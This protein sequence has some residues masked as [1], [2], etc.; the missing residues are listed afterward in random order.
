MSAF[1]SGKFWVFAAGVTLLVLSGAALPAWAEDQQQPQQQ[2]QRLSDQ[3]LQQLVAPIALYPDPLLAQILTASTYPLEVVMAARWS[4]DNPNLKGQDLENAMQNQPWDP[5]VKGLAAVPQVLAMM[6]DKLDWTQQLG[7]AFLAQADDI[8]KA[9]Q[10]LRTKAEATGNLK[11]TKEQRVRRVAASPPPSG[12]VVVVPEYIAI[13]PIEPDVIYVP[14]YDPVVIYGP[15]YW[16]AAYVP[17]FWYPPWWTVGPVWGFWP[18]YYVGPALWCHYNWGFGFVQINVVQYNKFNHANIVS[19]GGMAK[20]QHDPKH[21]AGLP[22]K[23]AI[24]QQKFGKASTQG[25]GPKGGAPKL[26]TGPKGGVKTLSAGGGGPKGGGPKSAGGPKGGSKTVAGGGTSHKPGGGSKGGTK[27]LSGGG[28]GGTSHKVSGG[29]GGPKHFSSGGGG[30]GPKHFSSGGGGPKVSGGGGGP[31]LGGGGPT[32]FR[33][34]GGG[35]GGGGGPR[36]GG[37][38][39]PPQKHH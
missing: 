8:T 36:S 5:S 19:G 37:G 30:G 9:V 17:F 16:P 34:A 20:W 3:E 1:R 14:I 25:G 23:T 38:G 39:G 2:Q 27:S 18:A 26:G 21:H 29:G 4:K 28:G 6:N 10:A 13:E 12:E 32:S 15:G 33:S 24:N 35:G 11:T 31:K 7:E 22:Y